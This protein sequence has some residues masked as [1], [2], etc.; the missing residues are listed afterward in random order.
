MSLLDGGVPNTAAENVLQL[1][2]AA[3]VCAAIV[4]LFY[5]LCRFYCSPLGKHLDRGRIR[6]RFA[7]LEHPVPID[8]VAYVDGRVSAR[9]SFCW[10]A[11]D[12]G[13]PKKTSSNSFAV[14]YSPC[15]RWA[16]CSLDP[17]PDSNLIYRLFRFCSPL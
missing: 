7:G 16:L 3:V 14:L 15:E 13:A 8:V 5:I 6:V 17:S 4:M 12:G 1:K 2:I 10:L 11:A 9:H